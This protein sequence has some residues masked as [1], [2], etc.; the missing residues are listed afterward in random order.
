MIR[1]K[2]WLRADRL[3]SVYLVHPLLCH[4]P[5]KN[6]SNVPILMYHSISDRP[7]KIRSAYFKTNTSPEDFQ[8]QMEFL[9]R[10]GYS[11]VSLEQALPILKGD[12]PKYAKLA[13]ITFDDGYRNILT[14]A[15]PVMRQYGFSATVFLATAF[16][17]E[18]RS[19]FNGTE[20]LTWSEIRKLRQHGLQFGSHT[21]NHP[22][23]YQMEWNEIERELR[24]SKR[25]N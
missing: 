16:V 25:G 12:Q 6:A 22:E 11:C 10:Q 2:N 4:S 24:D 13:V 19:A 9:H 3:L 14:D 8:A 20:C 23:L 7:E 1:T 21:V 15:F 17:G 18:R 5:S